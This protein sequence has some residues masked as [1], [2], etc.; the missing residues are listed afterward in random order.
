M[1]DK[2]DRLNRTLKAIDEA[3]SADPGRETVG[4]R[5]MPAAM[6]Y[7][8]HMTRWLHE[9]EPEPP[10]DV[11]IACRAQHIERWRI[12]RA[13]Y[14]EGR[15][16]YYEWRQACGRFHAER[17]AEIMA[18]CGYDEAQREHVAQMLTKRELK[19][20]PDTQLMEDVACLV[21]LERYFTPFYEQ[22]QDYD[23]DKWLRIVQR[24]W[25]KMSPRGREAALRLTERLPE[26]LQ[27]LLGEA[28]TSPE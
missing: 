10:E 12:P 17:T 21:F 23:R 28:L 20:D 25:G 3:N 4:D 8:E 6:A 16:G 1:I 26:H 9:L 5:E 27:Q 11:Q 24:T 14:P 15:K 18:G 7:S 2:T 19:S 13:D 22:K